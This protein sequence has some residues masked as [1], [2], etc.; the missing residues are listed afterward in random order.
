MP[1]ATA[2]E[3]AGVLVSQVTSVEQNVRQNRSLSVGSRKKVK[4]NRGAWDQIA[5]NHVCRRVTGT[6]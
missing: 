2:D 4:E 6:Y 3:I 1:I 5:A